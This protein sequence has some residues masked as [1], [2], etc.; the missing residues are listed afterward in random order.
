MGRGVPGPGEPLRADRDDPGLAQATLVPALAP[1][2]GGRSPA[3]RDRTDR[4]LAGPVHH[5][6]AGLE[7]TVRRQAD[8]IRA[9]EREAQELRKERQLL[10]GWLE[11]HTSVGSLAD[12]E[13]LIARYARTKISG[14]GLDPD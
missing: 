3:A 7:Q 2:A 13:E 5:D 14:Y 9:L 10:R 12:R 8:L 6:L 4:G 1:R 11:E